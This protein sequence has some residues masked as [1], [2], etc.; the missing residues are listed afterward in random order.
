[1]RSIKP[2]SRLGAGLAVVAAVL[3][4]GMFT[5]AASAATPTK[6]SF[7]QHPGG[8]WSNGELCLTGNHVQEATFTQSGTATLHFPMHHCGAGLA[9]QSLQVQVECPSVGKCWAVSTQV[10]TVLA[11]QGAWA[12]WLDNV[13]TPGVTPLHVALYGQSFDVEI[14]S[15]VF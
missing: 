14:H 10:V 8:F 15:H 3:G 6:F 7:L 9:V 2:W 1:M 12:Y 5:S 13:S 4:S 11:E